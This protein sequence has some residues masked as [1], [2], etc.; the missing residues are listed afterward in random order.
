MQIN[1]VLVVSRHTKISMIY[2]MKSFTAHIAENKELSNFIC[3]IVKYT[4]KINF[5]PKILKWCRYIGKL[6]SVSMKT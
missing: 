6:Q 4:E 3:N 1:E 5:I 2:T